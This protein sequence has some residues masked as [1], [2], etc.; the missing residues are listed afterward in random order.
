MALHSLKSHVAFRFGCDVCSLYCFTRYS[1][2]G[3]H[4]VTLK[5]SAAFLRPADFMQSLSPSFLKI[6]MVALFDRTR[7]QSWRR[8]TSFEISPCF[9][10]NCLVCQGICI[11]G[12]LGV[13]VSWASDFVTSHVPACRLLWLGF[14]RP[15][16]LYRSQIQGN[17]AGLNV[18][19]LV[20]DKILHVF[21]FSVLWLT[22]GWSI[23]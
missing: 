2:D 8:M 23:F 19:D 21:A 11:E 7:C 15:L 14:T 22:E 10:T 9:R 3:S 16:T 1:P 18:K 20:D 4:F 13:K 17:L 5:I 6:L 12:D